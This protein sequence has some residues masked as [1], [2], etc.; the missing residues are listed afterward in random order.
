MKNQALKAFFIVVLMSGLMRLAF[1]MQLLL[2]MDQQQRNH[3]KA[4]GIAYWAIQQG[5]SVQWLL[6]YRGGAF[7]CAFDKKTEN[8]IFQKI[9]ILC[10][11]TGG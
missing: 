6:N 4:Y 11:P 5:Q 7:L 9:G 1:G 3:L 8:S 10:N 2:P